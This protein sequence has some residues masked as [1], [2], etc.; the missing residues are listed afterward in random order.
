MV[1]QTQIISTHESRI[2][3]NFCEITKVRLPQ[4]AK[5]FVHRSDG[6]IQNLSMEPQCMETEIEITNDECSDG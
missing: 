2:L 4:I 1:D 6:V 5:G 3:C